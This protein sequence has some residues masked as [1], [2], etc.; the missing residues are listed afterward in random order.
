MRA[1]RAVVA[2]E[3]R[4]RELFARSPSPLFLHRRGVVF[5]GNDAAARL[6]GFQSAAAMNG[7]QIVGLFGG[8]NRDRVTQRLARLDQMS[9]G[10]GLDVGD[11]QIRS[12]DGRTLTVQA[13]NGLAG[14]PADS[15]ASKARM[16]GLEKQGDRRAASA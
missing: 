13:T 10:E 12:L 6:F 9:V 2:S 3:T 16:H 7:F 14:D 5:D 15:A 4:Y 8:G 11:F 1:E